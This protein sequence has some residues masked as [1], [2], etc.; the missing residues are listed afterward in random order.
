MRPRPRASVIEVDP[1]AI[2]HQCLMHPDTVRSHGSRY[3]D[4]GRI[5]PGDARGSRI[6]NGCK[7]RADLVESY[8]VYVLSRHEEWQLIRERLALGVRGFEARDP[9]HPDLGE[10]RA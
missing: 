6:G 2:R 4:W 1:R 8:E 10:L 9:V 7:T 5:V 3:Y